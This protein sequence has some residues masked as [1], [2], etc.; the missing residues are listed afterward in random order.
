MEPLSSYKPLN[1][2]DDNPQ[3]ERENE[4]RNKNA[5]KYSMSRQSNAKRLKY[6]NITS[7]WNQLPKSKST[8]A[9]RKK[10]GVKA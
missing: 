2:T 9:S 5:T 7:T 10:S 3:E 1:S 6:N 8:V 4:V